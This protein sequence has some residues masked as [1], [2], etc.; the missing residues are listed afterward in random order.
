V[1]FELGHQVGEILAPTAAA[2][3]GLADRIRVLAS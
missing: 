1:A 3:A 2:M